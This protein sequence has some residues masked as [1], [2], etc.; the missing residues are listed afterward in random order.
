[1]CT[2]YVYVINRLDPFEDGDRF[3]RYRSAS[4]LSIAVYSVLDNGVYSR[5][6][7]DNKNCNAMILETKRVGLVWKDLRQTVEISP[8][9]DVSMEKRF[10]RPLGWTR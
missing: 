4:L 5:A 1:M 8:L 6:F 9:V 7:F 2:S 10:L 3:D